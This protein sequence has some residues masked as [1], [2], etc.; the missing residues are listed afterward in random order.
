MAK[1]TH[2]EGDLFVSYKEEKSR[3]VKTFLGLVKFHIIDGPFFLSNPQ[4]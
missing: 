1:Q 4:R 3:M 2:H